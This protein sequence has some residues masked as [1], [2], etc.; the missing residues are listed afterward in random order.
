MKLS[1][2][3]HQTA[4]YPLNRWRSSTWGAY[5]DHEVGNTGGAGHDDADAD[6]LAVGDWDTPEHR[7][8]Q[9]ALPPSF[10]RCGASW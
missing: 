7:R 5:G 10:A 9:G 8:C 3:L 2:A 4:T 6:R 1:T